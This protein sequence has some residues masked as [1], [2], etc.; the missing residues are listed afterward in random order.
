MSSFDLLVRLISWQLD[1]SN[2]AIGYIDWDLDTLQPRGVYPIAA[3][4]GF[5][6]VLLSDNSY[7]SNFP[8]QT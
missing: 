3:S 1:L 2:Y 8:G 5:T 6:V 4:N 7:G